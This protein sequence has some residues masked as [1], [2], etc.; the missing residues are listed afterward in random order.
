MPEPAP[1][2]QGSREPS[3]GSVLRI[4]SDV[5]GLEML[6]SFVETRARELG[7]GPSAVYDLLLAANELVTNIMT[8]GYQ[9]SLGLIEVEMRRSGSAVE[10]VL[11]DAAPV[12]D[13]TSVAAPDTTLPL[14]RRPVGGLGIHMAR[15]FVD[16]ITH[17][18]LPQGGNELVLVKREAL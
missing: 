12:F 1:G 7:L 8:H 18:A 13:P 10:V 9:G 4:A 6:R 14:D 3:R 16:S 5:A 2:N 17:R 11:R 15:H